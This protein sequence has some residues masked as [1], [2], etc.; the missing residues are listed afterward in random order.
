MRAAPMRRGRAEWRAALL[1]LIVVLASA[2]CPTKEQF[3]AC[4]S[5]AK[6]RY[7]KA[8]EVL[9]A[10][11]SCFKAREC[12]YLK[13]AYFCVESSACCSAEI[14][15]ALAALPNAA[16][17][18]ATCNAT[19]PCSTPSSSAAAGAAASGCC[20]SPPG[21]LGALRVCC[22]S[23]DCSLC[24]QTL[25]AHVLE[26]RTVPTDVHVRLTAT[27]VGSMCPHGTANTTSG[28]ICNKR[29]SALGGITVASTNND[30]V[31]HSLTSA[32]VPFSPASC[33]NCCILSF[34]SVQDLECDTGC[35]AAGAQC[36]VC[37]QAGGKTAPLTRCAG[38][39]D[40]DTCSSVGAF[41]KCGGHACSRSIATF[42][43]YL[44]TR[45]R[46][47]VMAP[48][49]QMYVWKPAVSGW[50]ILRYQIRFE[51]D[52]RS[53]C[54]Y[55][56]DGR[57]VCCEG[58]AVSG[59]FCAGEET[60]GSQDGGKCVA[61]CNCPFG[62]DLTSVG[63][64][65]AKTTKFGHA[66]QPCWVASGLTRGSA[67]RMFDIRLAAS[68]ATLRFHSKTGFADIKPLADVL[69]VPG[70]TLTRPNKP[71][72]NR[73]SISGAGMVIDVE[74][75]AEVKRGQT[76]SLG[77]TTFTVLDET[78]AALRADMCPEAYQLPIKAS[79]V[80]LRSYVLAYSGQSIEAKDAAGA[81][82]VLMSACEASTTC[83]SCIAF[84]YNGLV[85]E[86][87]PFAHSC[88]AS[89]T[90]EAGVM[91]TRYCGK[92]QPQLDNLAG[93]IDL[94][95]SPVLM[96]LAFV[97]GV[98]LV[99]LSGAVEVWRFRKNKEALRVHLNY[100]HS[101]QD[102]EA[103]YTESRRGDKRLLY[104]RKVARRP[105][106][107]VEYHDE[108][109]QARLADPKTP[110]HL[111]DGETVDQHFAMHGYTTTHY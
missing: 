77:G 21:A 58:R 59:T 56:A 15:Q 87:Q 14:K 90:S 62:S 32:T 11:T 43:W 45:V 78:H 23:E 6:Q 83:A 34:D 13:D 47:S 2:Q 22:R 27:D 55:R 109:M 74:L 86:W 4:M 88:V 63:A 35:K 111:M 82:M 51:K 16:T 92:P 39:K 41:S 40:V 57:Q 72:L 69:G 80:T 70:A 81:N 1:L 91:S 31:Y 49:G 5:T 102:H 75:A 29:C 64:T 50:L 54:P 46:V 25:G 37:A 36:H 52:R 7:D 61:D 99:L 10:S 95:R 108:V 67:C 93:D 38:Y 66:Q 105:G 79:A 103:R 33:D 3:D 28:Y 8:K 98:V 20:P 85:C 106:G 68:A 96:V 97:P 26:N 44:H 12:D 100:E 19:S 71:A 30:Y 60:C 42:A 9:G 76:Y 94:F 18:V 73:I 24:S 101:L 107:H 17:S 89:G 110:Q 53:C 65:P 104:Q 84:E 48:E